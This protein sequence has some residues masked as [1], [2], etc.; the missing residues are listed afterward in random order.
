MASPTEP[1]PWQLFETA[2]VG[3][4]DILVLIQDFA[5][6]ATWEDGQWQPELPYWSGCGCCSSTPPAP[7]HWMPRHPAPL[8]LN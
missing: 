4:P 5:I 6:Q 3:G 8:V 2:P 1:N 7:S